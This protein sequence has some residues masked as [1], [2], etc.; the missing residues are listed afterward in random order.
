MNRSQTPALVRGSIRP[1][2]G[3]TRGV[4]TSV[5][6]SGNRN[7]AYTRHLASLAQVVGELPERVLFG[8]RVDDPPQRVAT[9]QTAREREPVA[10]RGVESAPRG[11]RERA[12]VGGVAVAEEER[13][14]ALNL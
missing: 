7:A 2:G 12:F 14:H 9:L 8:L 4:G 5:R 6:L 1:R 11:E 10:Q 13:R 3:A